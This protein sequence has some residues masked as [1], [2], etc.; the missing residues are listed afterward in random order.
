MIHQNHLIHPHLHR[1]IRVAIPIPIKILNKSN[2]NKEMIDK[3]TIKAEATAD[4]I[5]KIIKINLHK[6]ELNF[7]L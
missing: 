3:T 2:I 7:T 5:N 1:L 6:G 4:L